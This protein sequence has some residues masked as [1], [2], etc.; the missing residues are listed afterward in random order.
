MKDRT[1]IFTRILYV[2]FVIGTIITLFIVYKNVDSSI[3][4]KFV[5]GYL[6]LSIFM[7]LYIFFI[8]IL[9]SRK[10]KWVE[11]R[12]KI[13]RFIALFVLFVVLNYSFDYF[14][15]PSNINL[16][17]IFSIALGLSFGISFIDVTLLKN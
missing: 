3:V 7:I 16:Y 13:L 6:F 4:F 2:L 12:K 15:R 14:F 10:L 1:S 9:N 5:M 17:R 11:V 8:T